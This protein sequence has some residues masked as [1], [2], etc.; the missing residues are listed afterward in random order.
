M[1]HYA[2]IAIYG[3]DGGLKMLVEAK[4]KREKSRGW[5]ARLRHNMYAHGQLP[6]VPYFLVALPDRFYL[7]RDM[8]DP[9]A[10]VDPQYSVDPTSVLRPYFDRAH[11]SSQTVTETGLELAVSAW[12]EK[13]ANSPN[14]P[15]S[16]HNEQWL[17]QSG[18][19]EAIRGGSVEVQALV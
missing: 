15:A 6:R 17:H 1:Q 4:S 5:A 11:T 16:L 2:D 13:M 8:A 19:L 9:Q 7:W 12:L 3:R 14:Q 10:L 18:L